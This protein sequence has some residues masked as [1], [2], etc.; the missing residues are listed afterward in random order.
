M[1][2]SAGSFCGNRKVSEALLVLIDVFGILWRD[3]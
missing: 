1:D 2:S 3:Q